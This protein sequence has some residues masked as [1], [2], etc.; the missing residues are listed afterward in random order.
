M[1]DDIQ[2]GDKVRLS[3]EGE[4][5]ALEHGDLKLDSGTRYYRNYFKIDILEK[6]NPKV[7][8]KIK[9][10]EAYTNLPIGTVLRDEYIPAIHFVR[11]V[12]GWM[13]VTPDGKPVFH[14]DGAWYDP[15]T[16]VYLPSES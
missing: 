13:T 16:L 7:G 8:D 14:V 10:A 2:V 15:R 11:C 4:V 12:D 5:T 3:A 1:T 9:G 6:R